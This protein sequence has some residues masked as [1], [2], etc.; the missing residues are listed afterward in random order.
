RPPC[1]RTDLMAVLTMLDARH[2]GVMNHQLANSL[3]IAVI[4]IVVPLKEIAQ[5][6]LLVPPALR[7][8]FLQHALDQRLSRLGL[9][10]AARAAGLP[11]KKKRPH[12]ASCHDRQSSSRGYRAPCHG[13]GRADQNRYSLSRSSVEAELHAAGRHRRGSTR[14]DGVSVAIA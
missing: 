9:V 10:G 2:L 8:L 7:I 4:E 11:A 3:E 13:R 5:L 12:P 1:F 14:Y 6:G